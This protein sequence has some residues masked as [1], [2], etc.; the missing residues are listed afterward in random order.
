MISLCISTWFNPLRLHAKCTPF[1]K[2]NDML[3]DQLKWHTIVNV[4]L[5]NWNHFLYKISFIKMMKSEIL[6]ICAIFLYFLL[7]MKLQT[8]CRSATSNSETIMISLASHVRSHPTPSTVCTQTQTIINIHFLS[9]LVTKY[10]SIY[11]RTSPFIVSS[12]Q[13]WPNQQNLCVQK[14][15]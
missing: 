5:S 4:T 15:Y 9:S 1:W 8:F 2:S 14:C 12:T 6:S 13:G 7:V 11:S 10:K 3:V